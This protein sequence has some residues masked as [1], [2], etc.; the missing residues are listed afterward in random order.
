MTSRLRKSAL[1]LN[2]NSALPVLLSKSLPRLLERTVTS[3]TWTKKSVVSD[4]PNATDHEDDEVPWKCLGGVLGQ[5]SSRSLR[6]IRV[7]SVFR[8][9]EEKEWTV[10]G[11]GFRVGNFTMDSS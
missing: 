8:G 10:E 9:I 11:I 3:L 4:N 1:I 5:A 7:P 2:L 6:F